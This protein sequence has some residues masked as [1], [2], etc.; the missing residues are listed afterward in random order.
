MNFEQAIQEYAEEPLTRQVIKD[1]LK[2]YQRPNDKISELIKAG[3]LTALKNGLYIAG[4]KTKTPM[5]EPFLVANHLRGPSYVSM[6]SALAYWGMI[7]ER[8]FEVISVTT[9]AARAYQTP[10]G[11]FSY[12]HA[13]LPY[14]AY[15]IRSVALTPRQVAL[16]ATPEKA[17][18]D[19]IVQTSGILLRSPGQTLDFLLEDLRIDEEVLTR[20]DVKEMDSW[21]AHTPKHSSIEMLIKTLRNL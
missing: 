17:L 18:C 7:P 19:K 8:T 14:Y 16:I 1:M 15:G 13:A 10:I 12:I 9:K 3:E 6:E 5:P 21:S 20:L 2:D 11:R 4:P